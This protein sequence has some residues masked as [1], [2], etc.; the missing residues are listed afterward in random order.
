MAGPRPRDV[1]RA[2]GLRRQQAAALRLWSERN[3][4]ARWR[5]EEEARGR[6]L[7]YHSVGTPGWGVN[8]VS[9]GR[10]R[11][12][13][14]LALELGYRFAPAESVTP[15]EPGARLAITFDDGCTTS[16]A[17]AAPILHEYGIPFTMFVVS[18]WADGHP[19]FR[20]GSVLGWRE[21]EQVARYGGAI[22]SH[23]VTHPNLSRESNEQAAYELGESRRVIASRLGIVP[24]DFAIPVGYGPSW[25]ARVHQIALEAGYRRIYAQAE[26]RRPPGTIGRTFVTRFDGDRLFRAALGGAFDRW[27]EWV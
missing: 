21:L 13:I 4:L 11:R 12:Q 1:L 27:E 24:A 22:G 26:D 10:F 25:D 3:A 2:C 18:G 19:R 7:C 6:I 15:G 8:D 17:N 5:P 14:E 9:P 23:S 20:D 16:L